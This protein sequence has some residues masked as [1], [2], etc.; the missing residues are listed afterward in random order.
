MCVLANTASAQQ[1]LRSASLPESRL[2]SSITPPRPDVYLAT[3]RTYAPRYDRL[4]RRP[5]FPGGGVPYF[6]WEARRD[7]HS[8]AA[9]LPADLPDGYLRLFVQPSTAEVH[10]DGYYV[11]TVDEFRRS[12]RTLEPGPHQVELRVAGRNNVTFEVLLASYETI[13][14]R[15]DF[16]QSAPA[17]PAPPTPATSAPPAAPKTFYVI[18]G[19]YAGDKRPDADRLPPACDITKLRTVPPVISNIARGR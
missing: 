11:G 17:A 14:Y 3:P 12:G 13:T 18:P 15:Y 6:G 8:R 1:G 4:Q 7:S 16:D 5:R 10:I 19:C 9:R 2:E